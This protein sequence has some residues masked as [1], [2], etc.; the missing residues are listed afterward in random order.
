MDDHL[1]RTYI[2]EKGIQPFEESFKGLP[3]AKM[4]SACTGT[5]G[6]GVAYITDDGFVIFWTANSASRLVPIGAAEWIS[7]TPEPDKVGGMNILIEVG[8]GM[9]CSRNGQP[10]TN[11]ENI[12]DGERIKKLWAYQNQITDKVELFGIGENGRI[13]KGGAYNDGNH[14]CAIPRLSICSM[15][16]ASRGITCGEAINAYNEM[17]TELKRMI[18]VPALDTYPQYWQPTMC[19]V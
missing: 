11:V 9:R 19:K 12:L 18:Y 5:Q 6:F 1:Y 4:L 13:Y 15:S 16:Y 7:C 10:V 14:S 8:E 17:T 2:N 3:K